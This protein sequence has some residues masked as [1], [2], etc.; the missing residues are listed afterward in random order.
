MRNTIFALLGKKKNNVM[1]TVKKVYVYAII[2]EW[3]LFQG[4]YNVILEH[5]SLDI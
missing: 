5:L 4:E 2:Y 1:L 3:N